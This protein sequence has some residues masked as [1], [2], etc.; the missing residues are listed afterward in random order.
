MR[1]TES[2]G[3]L[4]V[5]SNCSSLDS[6]VTIRASRGQPRTVPVSS[7]DAPSGAL[8]EAAPLTSA[9]PLPVFLYPPVQRNVQK[10]AVRKM[11]VPPSN[12]RRVGTT[13]AGYFLT[14][15]QSEIVFQDQKCCDLVIPEGV[16]T[17]LFLTG[18]SWAG[19]RV[20]SAAL[21][22]QISLTISLPTCTVLSV[23]IAPAA[24]E[25][26]PITWSSKSW[27]NQNF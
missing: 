19:R 11:S 3:F 18:A 12:A 4:W 23:A 13:W 24:L 6:Q 21:R 5:P 8:Q 9:D 15:K 17:F 22:F 25:L 16:M 10:R 1:W 14:A 20:W 27:A 2:W 26:M 7:N